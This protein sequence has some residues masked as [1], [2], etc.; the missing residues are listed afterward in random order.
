[1]VEDIILQ[2]ITTSDEIEMSMTATFP[3]MHHSHHRMLR[4]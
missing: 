2:N 3:I 4:K 1:M